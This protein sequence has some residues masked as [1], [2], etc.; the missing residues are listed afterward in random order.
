TQVQNIKCHDQTNG[1]IN[2]AVG[3]GTPT[4]TYNWT[5][6]NN[7]TATTEDISGLSAG[8]YSV[9]VTDTKGCTDSQ[10][11]TI[12]N[13]AVLA[14]SLATSQNVTCFGAANGKATINSG[15]GT[16]PLSYAWYTSGGQLFSTTKNP[17]NLI[18]D[19]YTVTVTDGSLCTTTL[20]NPVIITGPGSPLSVATPVQKTD[21]VCWG[22]SNGSINLN[23]NGGWGTY[24]VTWDPQPYTGANLTGIPGG[25]YTP[26]ITDAG[27]CTMT[28]PAIQVLEP[29][30]V[31]YGTPVV[32][33]NICA[34]DGEGSINI[35]VSGGNDGPFQV[36]WTGNLSGQSIS[37]LAGGQYIPTITDG[38]QCTA[39]LPAITV[40]EPTPIDTGAVIII[41]PIGSNNDGAISPDLSGG[42]G[43]LTFSWTGPNGFTAN[44]E[45]ITNLAAG[46]YNLS[47]TDGNNCVFTAS[48]LVGDA[49][50]AT[51]STSASCG[52]DGCMNVNIASGT[53]PF[54]ISWTGTSSG[55]ATANTPTTS[56]CTFS[57][58]IYNLTIADNANH[59]LTINSLSIGALEPALAGVQ[60]NN[61]TGD[62]GNGS[63]TLLPI[64]PPG[65]PV[66]F[67][68]SWQGPNGP[69][70]G[71]QPGQ[72]NLDHGTY[73][74][75]V[76]NNNS[77]CTS[78]YTET[79]VR[80]WEAIT[81]TT[82]TVAPNCNNTPTG[83]ITITVAGGND[84]Y[85]YQ[86]A[87]P[88][89]PL[90]GNEASIS[91]LLAGAYTVTVTDDNDSI[92]VFNI[93]L[94]PQ[95]NLAVTNVNETSSYGNPP[96]QVSGANQCDGVASVVF[97]G[98]VGATSILWSNNITGVQNTTL[99]A[100]AY[101][102][103]VTDA[104]GCV[105]VWS[106]SLTYP[107]GVTTGIA[108]I[109]QVSCHGECDGVVRVTVNGGVAPYTVKWSTGQ[110]DQ[111]AA[112]G[113]FSQA[114]NL[115]GRD[116][117][118]TV[119]DKLGA[120]YTFSVPLA[121]PPAIIVN[122]A[123]VDPTTFNSCNGELIAETPGAADP[124]TYTWSGS[125]GHSGQTQ[126][127][128][129]LCAGEIVEFVITDGNGCTGI[130]R[131]TIAYPEDGC[132]QVR[133]VITPGDQDGNNDFVIIT[134]IEVVPNSIEIYNRWGQLV[135]ETTGYDNAGNV[136]K[137]LT[138]NGQPLAEGVYFYVLNYTDPTRGAQQQKGHINLLR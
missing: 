110:T 86:W 111:V 15:G 12:S 5:G 128:E 102:V 20:P 38:N 91:G 49:L 47:V 100:G 18:P 85:T 106:D 71:N 8:I 115:C 53:P 22:Y 52:N 1:A 66:N 131:D 68:F 39:V 120:S 117:S 87:G 16:P 30:A 50:S 9:Q 31:V 121:E 99:C 41:Q 113:G 69:I 2:L 43:T 29:P 25:L 136:W 6:P 89:G 33:H 135:F 3:G 21:L 125:Y 27:N 123:S 103:S 97:N 129:G 104:L 57:P 76:T 137:G 7:F 48:F 83:S 95:S 81:S 133:P 124:L 40:N 70:A 92:K 90:A 134:C 51:V 75:T 119:T 122:F 126:R 10:N 45:D 79:L 88:N 63:I 78:I 32:V 34:N 37:N 109:S 60:K 108:A 98:G 96:F 14:L 101:S 17:D 46:T 65:S 93:T 13:P 72:T 59:T 19:T 107:A 84:P 82:S 28:L 105:S 73:T 54:I 62:L 35:Q 4:F 11:F 64:V 58:G 80:Q 138:K 114:V 77:G 24:L 118:V 36:Q 61:P 112:S 42:T 26:T 55:L 44:T 74:I 116:Y 23:I 130:G 94:T 127:A 56:I 132:Y 67:S